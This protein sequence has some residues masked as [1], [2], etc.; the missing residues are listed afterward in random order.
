MILLFEPFYSHIKIKN[1]F[2]KQ[3][4]KIIANPR[5]RYYKLLMSVDRCYDEHC[6]SAS[7]IL[8]NPN[9]SFN[10]QGIMYQEEGLGDSLEYDLIRSAQNLLET[11]V[12][13]WFKDYVNYDFIKFVP[14]VQ[15]R[16]ICH[17]ELYYMMFKRFKYKEQ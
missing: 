11:K 14:E 7:M 16:T 17:T 5:K 15:T 13:D 10:I 4:E 8:Y 3:F 12:R 6:I 2:I 1:Q 9:G